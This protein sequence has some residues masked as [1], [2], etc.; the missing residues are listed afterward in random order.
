MKIRS[1]LPAFPERYLTIVVIST[2][3]VYNVICHKYFRIDQ[4]SFTRA[5]Y[6][7]NSRRLTC[8]GRQLVGMG[9]VR[10]NN[11]IYTCSV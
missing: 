4:K 9:V 11:Y 3:N 6:H 2:I 7:L 8:G 1:N 10:M 5:K